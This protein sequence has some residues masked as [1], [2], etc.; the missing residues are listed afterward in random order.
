MF[1]RN[2]LFT[3][4]KAASLAEEQAISWLGKPRKGPVTRVDELGICDPR[5]PPYLVEPAPIQGRDW[6]QAKVIDF[7]NCETHF[8]FENCY[9]WKNSLM[10]MKSLF[11]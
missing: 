6:G 11:S 7:G 5:I 9:S 10:R 2:V 3:E 8:E 1:S 4:S